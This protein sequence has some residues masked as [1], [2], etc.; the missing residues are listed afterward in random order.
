MAEIDII[1]IDK[2]ENIGF[3]WYIDNLGKYGWI[4]WY[5]ILVEWKLINIHRNIG[6]NSKNDNKK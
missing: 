1:D 4:F 6:E 3:D 2:D 5:K